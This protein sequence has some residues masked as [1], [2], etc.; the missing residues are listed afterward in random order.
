MSRISGINI[1]GDEVN[2]EKHWGKAIASR[3]SRCTKAAKYSKMSRLGQTAS[4]LRAVSESG[5]E[6]FY[7]SSI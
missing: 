2:R 5:V 7:L 6:I 4:S 3:A 1:G